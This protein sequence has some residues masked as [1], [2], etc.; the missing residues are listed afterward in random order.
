MSGEG[1]S[2]K[3]KK[4]EVEED[5]EEGDLI[6]FPVQ[7]DDGGFG[8]L[9]TKSAPDFEDAPVLLPGGVLSETNLT[10]LAGDGYLV[11][12]FYPL[13]WTFVCPTEII[14][15]S[16]RIDEFKKL[17][18]AVVGVSVDSIYSHLAWTK[19]PRNKGGIGEMK[20]PLIGD[21]TKQISR[22]YG[23]L[24][25]E[26]IALRGLFIIDG[27]GIIRHI[28]MNDPPVGRNVD[29]VL[30]L[31]AA[32]QHNDNKGEVCPCNWKPG[33]DTIIPTPEDSLKF[34]AKTN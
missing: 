7:A 15:F 3:R 28:T 14:A 16:D 25:D 32:Y 33:S 29:E 1:P 5:I 27:K 19:T 34:F 20:I 26:G 2:K 24:M 23:V 17:N 4:S 21:I 11:I 8:P 13:D 6:S 12:F 31:V 30:R 10:K 18:C 22:D 9:V